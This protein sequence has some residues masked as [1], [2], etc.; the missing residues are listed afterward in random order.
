MNFSFFDLEIGL[1][2]TFNFNT[3]FALEL[4]RSS[5]L[6][7]FQFFLSNMVSTDFRLQ[8]QVMR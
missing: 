4:P 5:K 7:S 6:S 3:I 2:S 1:F 8:H